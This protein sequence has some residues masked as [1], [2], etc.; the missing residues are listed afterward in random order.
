MR[1]AAIAKFSLFA[2]RRFDDRAFKI[3]TCHIFVGQSLLREG[4]IPSPTILVSLSTT[5][6]YEDDLFAWEET[7]ETE[8]LCNSTAPRHS[9]GTIAAIVQ[10]AGERAE[11]WMKAHL[12][13]SA[14]GLALDKLVLCPKL[15]RNETGLRNSFC[16]RT[17][18][19]I[20]R[21]PDQKSSSCPRSSVQALASYLN[22]SSIFTR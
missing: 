11:Q 4:A 19:L 9:I 1:D 14:R 17:R 21:S 2:N 15:L 16:H 20:W 18:L 7:K 13:A 10:E 5:P 8:P 12:P 22:E 3:Q 6:P